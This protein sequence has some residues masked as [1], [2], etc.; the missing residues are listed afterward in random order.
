[1]LQINAIPRCAY[2]VVRRRPHG[3]R[4]ADGRA[5]VSLCVIVW[6]K[7]TRGQH[8]PDKYVLRRPVIGH[9]LTA[10]VQFD[11]IVVSHEVRVAAQ[12]FHEM[13]ENVDCAAHDSQLYSEMGRAFII[14][15]CCELLGAHGAGVTG[16][17][18]GQNALGIDKVGPRDPDHDVQVA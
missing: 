18:I 8:P 9:R 16:E 3:P 11:F 12:G 15:E 14:L 7:R 1:L 5:L 2:L 10:T 13:M 17:T 6:T 4:L